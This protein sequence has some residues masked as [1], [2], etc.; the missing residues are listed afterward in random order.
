MDILLH[1]NVELI[2]LQVVLTK[3]LLMSK[4]LDKKEIQEILFIF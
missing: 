1:A 3:L 4:L 2:G